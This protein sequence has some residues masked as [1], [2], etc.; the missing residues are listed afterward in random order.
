MNTETPIDRL[1]EEKARRALSGGFICHKCGAYGLRTSEGDCC[2][3]LTWEE[4]QDARQR[5]FDTLVEHYLESE[6]G[7]LL[8]WREGV[9]KTRSMR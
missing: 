1:A 5:R 3:W 4:Q 6:L 7:V 2:R 8:D 9:R